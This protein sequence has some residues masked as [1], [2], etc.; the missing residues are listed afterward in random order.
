MALYIPY[1]IFHLARL[2]YVRPETFGP[3]YVCQAGNFWTLLRTCRE[4]LQNI[5]WTHAEDKDSIRLKS[6][7]ETDRTYPASLNK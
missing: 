2:L 5:T 4:W 6:L 1:S 7:S 3:Y